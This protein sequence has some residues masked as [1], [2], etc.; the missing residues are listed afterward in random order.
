MTAM[1]EAFTALC[2]FHLKHSID[3]GEKK[4]GSTEDTLNSNLGRKPV[5]ETAIL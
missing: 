4:V 2:L 1:T 5:L 3:S